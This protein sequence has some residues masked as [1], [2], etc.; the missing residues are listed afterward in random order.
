MSAYTIEAIV[1]DNEHNREFPTFEQAEEYGKLLE[2]HP[3]AVSYDLR[4]APQTPGSDYNNLKHW[5]TQERAAVLGPEDH[6]AALQA[7]IDECSP[8]KDVPR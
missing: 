7:E 5:P 3:L 4:H 8:Q 1:G 2:K 6:M